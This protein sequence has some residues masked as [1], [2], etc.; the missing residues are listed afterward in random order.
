LKKKERSN[1]Q[2]YVCSSQRWT[3]LLPSN[4]ATKM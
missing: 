1:I 3:S 4:G 2:R